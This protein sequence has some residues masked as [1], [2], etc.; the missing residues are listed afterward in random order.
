MPKRAGKHF[1][2]L[3]DWCASGLRKCVTSSF[4]V[5]SKERI[6]N[7]FNIYFTN[8]GHEIVSKIN[9]KVFN[10]HHYNDNDNGNTDNNNDDDDNNNNNN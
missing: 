3:L 6:A 8:I 1:C 4:N 10:S 2:F 7:E 9:E 5:K